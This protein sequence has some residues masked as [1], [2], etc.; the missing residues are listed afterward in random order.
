MAMRT[1]IRGTLALTAFSLVYIVLDHMATTLIGS[2]DTAPSTT[3]EGFAVIGFMITAMAAG[4]L[5]WKLIPE[6]GS[7]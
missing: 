2:M 6:K 5:V 3:R 7:K 4:V 1:F